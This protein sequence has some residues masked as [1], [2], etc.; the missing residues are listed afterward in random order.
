MRERPILFSGPMVRAILACRKT[1]TRRALKPH[2]PSQTESIGTYHHPDPRPHFWAYGDGG[3]LDWAVPCPYGQPGDRLWVREAWQHANHPLGPYQRGT[4]V[5]YR[6]DYLDDPHGPDGE[7][8]SEGGY[9]TWRPSIHMPRSACRLVLEITAVR[10]ERLQD[11]SETDAL[12]EGIEEWALGALSPEG[13]QAD[14]TEQFRW[15]WGSINGPGSW[16]ANPW[17]WVVKFRPLA[18]RTQQ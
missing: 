8:S 15:L 9:R 12:A 18:A 1:M 6:A 10:V 7:R 5:Y 2:P 11:I 16:Y 13:R 3:L 4:P 17:V 14:P